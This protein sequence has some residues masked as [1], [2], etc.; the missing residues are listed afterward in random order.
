MYQA[1]TTAEDDV[2]YQ[3]W[4][5]WVLSLMMKTLFWIGLLPLTAG[6]INASFSGQWGLVATYVLIYSALGWVT[7][8]KSIVT[9]VA[10]VYVWLS[11]LYAFALIG[12]I[13][14]G[15]S[16]DGRVFLFA[17]VCNTTIL[18]GV[19]GGLVAAAI[20]VLTLLIV[21]GLL[22]KGVYTLPVAMLANSDQLLPWISGSLVLLF[23]IL[24]IAFPCAYLLA[25]FRT[26]LV[27]TRLAKE[28][29]ERANRA[30]SEFLARMSHEL[31]TPLNA[32]IG[33]AALI[34]EEAEESDALEW[35]GDLGKIQSAGEALLSLIQDVLDFSRLDLGKLVLKPRRVEVSAIAQEAVGRVESLA[36]RNGNEMRC[37]LP[38]EAL[39]M[40][41]DADRLRQILLNLLHNA[42][43]FTEKGSIRLSFQT[44]K[45]KDTDSSYLS[46]ELSGAGPWI[47]F[48]IAD[49]GRGIEESLRERMF[50]AFQGGGQYIGDRP[51]AGLGLSICSHLCHAMGGSIQYAP[52]TEGPGSRFLVRLPLE[53]A[54]LLSVTPAP[55]DT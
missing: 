40:E 1:E 3:R 24:S 22:V 42:A 8:A 20:S 37:V 44:G 14:A 46:P 29:A 4:R 15:L 5:S 16:G 7:F 45:G 17:L 10:K 52:Q 41:V 54:T 38:D 43:K 33:Y 51:G 9:Y 50:E 6:I 26:S 30:K 28:E 47:D 55:T 53:A 27:Q 32:I 34:Q 35:S 48:E 2:A 12:L 19:R 36:V 25:R 13:F 49:T 11:V 23:M 31:R 39:S 18:L 21:G